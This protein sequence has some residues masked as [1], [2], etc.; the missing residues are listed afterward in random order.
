MR[1]AASTVSVGGAVLTACWARGLAVVRCGWPFAGEAE[2]EA[3]NG[4]TDDAPAAAIRGRGL[5]LGDMLPC[6]PKRWVLVRLV[7]AC[8]MK[9]NSRW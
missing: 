5:P 2:A 4:D 9:K 1:A 3:E 7:L 6:M 8:I